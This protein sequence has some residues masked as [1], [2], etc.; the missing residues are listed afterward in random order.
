M[1][2]HGVRNQVILAIQWD[3]QFLLEELADTGP[4]RHTDVIVTGRKNRRALERAVL[5]EQVPNACVANGGDV[6]AGLRLDAQP[7]GPQESRNAG[8]DDVV[9]VTVRRTPEVGEERRAAQVRLP[10]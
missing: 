2:R 3:L 5:L 7:A 6:V 9:R 1:G 10:S 4:R 8:L